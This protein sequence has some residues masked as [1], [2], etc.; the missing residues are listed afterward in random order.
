MV[1]LLVTVASVATIGNL[2]LEDIAAVGTSGATLLSDYAS[3]APL[4]IE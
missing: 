4:A 3:R 1:L 2:Y